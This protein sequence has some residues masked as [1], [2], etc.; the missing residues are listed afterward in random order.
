MLMWD[1][2]DEFS[3]NASSELDWKTLSVIN[4]KLLEQLF[5]SHPDFIIFV[6]H[7]NVLN[8]SK[9]CV[10]YV[11]GRCEEGRMEVAQWNAPPF[12]RTTTPLHRC[13]TAPRHH[14]A[15]APLHYCTMLHCTMHYSTTEPPNHFVL[16]FI[17]WTYAL[18]YLYNLF[19]IL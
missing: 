12:H 5:W 9:S 3:T 13:T 16:L 2:P 7:W 15:T 1:K 19:H 18:R 17:H 14:G 11:Y 10:A 6:K 4:K 8:I